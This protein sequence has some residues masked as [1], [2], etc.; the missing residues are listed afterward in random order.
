MKV[1]K[2]QVEFNEAQIKEASER[3]A[4]KPNPN[5]DETRNNG[6]F[7]AVIIIVS[8]VAAIYSLYVLAS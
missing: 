4:K 2:D 7:N 1:S 6:C 3:F 5:D 8:I